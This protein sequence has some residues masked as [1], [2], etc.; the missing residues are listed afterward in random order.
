MVCGHFVPSI[1]H[2]RRS[3]RCVGRF[4][5]SDVHRVFRRFVL[6]D[7]CQPTGLCL[8]LLLSAWLVC[9]NPMPRGQLLPVVFVASRMSRWSLECSGCDHLHLLLARHV[10]CSEQ[11]NLI[12]CRLHQLSG[13]IVLHWRRCKSGLQRWPL[14]HADWPSDGTLCVSLV[15]SRILLPFDEH[16]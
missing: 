16:S 3:R 6:S 14:R 9:P 13:C 7:A 12:G 11:S 4:C 10:R 15:P 1:Q 8:G 5:P 2:K